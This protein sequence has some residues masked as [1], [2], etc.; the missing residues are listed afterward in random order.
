MLYY[1]AK[2]YSSLFRV[3]SLLPQAV[4]QV[5]HVFASLRALVVQAFLGARISKAISRPKRLTHHHP[6]E[7]STM[8]FKFEFLL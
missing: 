2:S 8:I 5:V 3:V 1:C 6:S 4:G 7:N